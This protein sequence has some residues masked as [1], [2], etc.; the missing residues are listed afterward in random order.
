MVI[1]LRSAR[2][3]LLAIGSEHVNEK[4]DA[5][6]EMVVPHSLDLTCKTTTLQPTAQSLAG[7]ERARDSMREITNLIDAG[8]VRVPPIEMLPLEDAAP[9]HRMIETG[10]VRGKLVLKV[11]GDWKE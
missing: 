9:A 5:D 8:L 2:E 1:P 4:Q 11:A 10:H 7:S 6:P 3:K